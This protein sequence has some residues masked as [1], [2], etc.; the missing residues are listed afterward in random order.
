MC[1]LRIGWEI[2]KKKPISRDFLTIS[3][4]VI[5]IEHLSTLC[6]FAHKLNDYEP[7]KSLGTRVCFSLAQGQHGDRIELWV[8][9][10]HFLVSFAAQ[11]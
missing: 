1:Y 5:R 9:T 11:K 7:E 6:N 2:E 8:F 10:E 3:V 4:F